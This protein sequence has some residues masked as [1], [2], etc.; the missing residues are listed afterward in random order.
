MNVQDDDSIKKHALIVED[1]A[2]LNK[3]FGKWFER[4]GYVVH[5]AFTGDEALTRLGAQQI[6][7]VML[8]QHLPDTTGAELYPRIK[9]RNDAVRVVVCSA[10]EP[11]GHLQETVRRGEASF[12]RKPCFFSDL[13]A[14]LGVLE[15]DKMPS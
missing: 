13:I 2:L 14:A 10:F 6:D 1:D 7:V 11:E 8:D 12:V 3:L 15:A 9:A 5:N 4:L